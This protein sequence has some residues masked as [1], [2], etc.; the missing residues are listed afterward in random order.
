MANLFFFER[1]HTKKDKMKH[2]RSLGIKN[3]DSNL[4]LFIKLKTIMI[5]SKKK[6]MQVTMRFALFVQKIVITQWLKEEIY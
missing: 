2:R 6:K 5:S 3:T 4:E 1:T